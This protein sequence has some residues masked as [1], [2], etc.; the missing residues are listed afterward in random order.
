MTSSPSVIQRRI[1]NALRD[2]E[3]IQA[4]LHPLTDDD[5]TVNLFN[6]RSRREDAVRLTVLQMSLAIE[7]ILDGLFWRIFRGYEPGDDGKRRRKKTGLNRELEEL[8]S[9]GRMGFEA[10]LKLAR[11]LRFITKK[12]QS[13]LDT[14]SSLRN[15]CAHRWILDVVRKRGYRNRATTRLLEFENKDLHEL[16]VLESFVRVYSGIY[17]ALF[18]RYFK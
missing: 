11:V 15:K 1:N 18:S 7:S 2:V 5:P 16:G 8:L 12:Q 14:L 4:L 17:L 3:K 13:R 6:A 10:K 9:S